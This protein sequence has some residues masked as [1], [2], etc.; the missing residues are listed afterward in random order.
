MRAQRRPDDAADGDRH[1]ET[2]RA[3]RVAV[4][5]PEIAVEQDAAADE[6]H[7]R[8]AHEQRF[9]R[10]GSR[11]ARKP[12]LPVD[13]RFAC[14]VHVE[15]HRFAVQRRGRNPRC[16]GTTGIARFPRGTDVVRNGRTWQRGDGHE[17]CRIEACVF[18]QV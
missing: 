17:R 15:I 16:P 1:A 5:E 8:E 18:E 3:A 10:L 4:P 14:T 7:D 12:R 2:P 11:A 6:Q 13:A 9:I